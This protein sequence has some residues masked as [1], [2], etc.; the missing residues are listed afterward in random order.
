MLKWFCLGVQNR[1]EG[2]IDGEQKGRCGHSFHAPFEEFLNQG[3]PFNALLSLQDFILYKMRK[4][5]VMRFGNQ[6]LM[7]KLF[8]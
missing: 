8:L 4:E 3:S 7:R 1:L 2:Y 5:L 6:N